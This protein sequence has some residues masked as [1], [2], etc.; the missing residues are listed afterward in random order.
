MH[1]RSLALLEALVSRDAGQTDWQY[2]L[3]V[4]HAK[5]GETLIALGKRDEALASYH[6]GHVIIKMLVAR[7]ASNA[8]WLND[9]GGLAYD[10]LLARDFAAALEAAEQTIAV[11]PE[12]IF[13]YGNR[14]HALM[15]LGRVDEARALYLK[16]RG[17]KNVQDDKSWETVTLQDF[18][19]LRKA[20]LKHPLMDEIEKQFTAGG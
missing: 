13:I 2:A 20:G 7:D 8:D 11:A 12:L 14:A 15:F 5:I 4:T 10:F 3:F 18:A 17:T 1:R 19:E 9:F 6:R 16:Y